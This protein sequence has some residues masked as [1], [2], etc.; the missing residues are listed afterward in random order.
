MSADLD[1]RP[2]HHR[3]VYALLATP[4]V[5][6]HWLAAA[7]GQTGKGRR[8][9]DD[10]AGEQIGKPTTTT[11]KVMGRLGL[12]YVTAIM[13]VLSAVLSAFI[14]WL[15]SF[16][17]HV[18]NYEVHIFLAAVIPF[19]VTPLFSYLSALSM[20]DLQ[21]ARKKAVDLARLDVLTGL[22]NRRAF[23][24][25]ARRL[26][27]GAHASRAV[28]FIDIDH[29]KSVNDTYGHDAGDAVLKHFAELLR[30]SIRAEDFAARIGGEEFALHVVDAEPTGLAAIASGL[31]ARVRTSAVPCGREV[32][33]YRVSIGGAIAAPAMEIDKLLSLADAQLYEVKRAGRDAVRITDARSAAD[34]G[35]AEASSSRS[36]A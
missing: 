14:A 5:A 31:L 29:F 26:E 10:P 36:A 11:V 28:L 17:I 21:R 19:F 4:R 15:F 7:L 20:R 9:T 18:P 22:G 35:G 6:R 1:P 30:A 25:T 23:F 27:A 12:L 13:T 33:R 8:R 34:A 24:E 16:V 2:R 32:I 3:V